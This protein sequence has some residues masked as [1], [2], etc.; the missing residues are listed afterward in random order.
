MHTTV[1][2]I[3]KCGGAKL[4]LLDIS[5]IIFDWTEFRNITL[6]A[7]KIMG[8]DNVGADAVYIRPPFIDQQR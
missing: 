2:C 6:T 1:A 8:H 5:Q 3:N 7:A 4:M